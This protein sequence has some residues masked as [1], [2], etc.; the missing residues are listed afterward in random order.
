MVWYLSMRHCI[1]LHL[2]LSHSSCSHNGHL[3]IYQG[4]HLNTFEMILTSFQLQQINI[5]ITFAFTL[6]MRRILIFGLCILMYL[7]LSSTFLSV[8][9]ANSMEQS[10]S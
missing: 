1:T 4:C 3:C 8:T 7:L 10:P 6:D 5:G 9:L 2:R